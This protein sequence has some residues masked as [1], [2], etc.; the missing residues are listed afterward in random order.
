[1]HYLLSDA[2]HPAASMPESAVALAHIEIQDVQVT[3]VLLAERPRVRGYPA[4]WHWSGRDAD[5]LAQWLAAPQQQP[6]FDA[7][8]LDQIRAQV[9]P[10]SRML[11]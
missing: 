4:T 3:V 9:Q 11:R 5:G 1:M 6:F 2:A 7:V 10:A 8:R